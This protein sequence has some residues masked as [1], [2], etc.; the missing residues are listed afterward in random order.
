MADEKPGDDLESYQNLEGWVELTARSHGRS[1][2]LL[3]KK[4]EE[5]AALTLEEQER[6]DLLYAVREICE[7]AMEWGNQ[8]DQSRKIRVSYGIFEGEFVLKV[9]DEGEGFDTS[10]VA[11]SLNP[12]DAM[13]KRKRDGKRPGGFGITMVTKLMD[14]V[15]YSDKGN[16]VLLSKNLRKGTQPNP[17]A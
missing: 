12:L 3:M 14:R 4:I 10:G 8:G 15:L 16:V 5:A 2:D 7:N 17:F 13:F 1:L 11:G 9:A 6:Q